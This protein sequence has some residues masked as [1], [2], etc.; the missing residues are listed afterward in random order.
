MKVAYKTWFHG[1]WH[2]CVEYSSW[3]STNIY[4]MYCKYQNRAAMLGSFNIQHAIVSRMS[5]I[6]Q[7]TLGTLLN[8]GAWSIFASS[9][10]F[11]FAWRFS[12]DLIFNWILNNDIKVKRWRWKKE[13]KK[14]VGLNIDWLQSWISFA[15][16]IEIPCFGYA[17]FDEAQKNN[18]KETNT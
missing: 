3:Y 8:S 17:W 16:W 6:M 7:M 14:N 12:M 2:L 4:F 5:T 11:L 9:W 13:K 15:T 18:E 10:N 1:T